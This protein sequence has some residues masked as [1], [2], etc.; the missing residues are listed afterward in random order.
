VRVVA[1][2]RLEFRVSGAAVVTSSSDT[3]SYKRFRR[4]SGGGGTAGLEGTVLQAEA[5]TEV[6]VLRLVLP[7]EEDTAQEEAIG[8]KKAARGT[9]RTL[10]RAHDRLRVRA[11]PL[12]SMK[13]LCV[14]VLRGGCKNCRCILKRKMKMKT[15]TLLSSMYISAIGT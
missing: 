5:G 9:G 4:G 7:S 13:G 6:A 10:A 12:K 15:D 11:A 1:R 14:I 2:S 8:R 3:S